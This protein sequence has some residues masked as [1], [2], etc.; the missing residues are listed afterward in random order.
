LPS[1]RAGCEVEVGIAVG[2]AVAV[3]A[4]VGVGVSIEV[5]VE[6]EAR[7]RCVGVLCTT[8]CGGVRY[9]RGSPVLEPLPTLGMDKLLPEVSAK[10]PPMKLPAFFPGVTLTLLLKVPFRATEILAFLCDWMT[11][12][13][14][15]AW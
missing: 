11:A 7:M 15:V 14:S 8:S 12:S 3:A 6:G 1:Q 10:L 13:L 2:I 5:V 4:G 9:V